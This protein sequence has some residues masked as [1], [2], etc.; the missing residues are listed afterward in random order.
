MG[1]I[2]RYQLLVKGRN[3]D[4]EKFKRFVKSEDRLLDFNRI[5][6]I[7]TKGHEIYSWKYLHNIHWGVFTNA[8]DICLS[9]SNRQISYE[10]NVFGEEPDLIVFRLLDLFPILEI[11]LKE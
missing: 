3:E 7:E 4:L 2:N 8:F 11:S 6:P 1:L 10:F 5:I 9:E